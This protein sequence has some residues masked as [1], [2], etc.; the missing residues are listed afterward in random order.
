MYSFLTGP[1][2]WITFLIFIFGT[3]IRLT[4]LAGL[5]K[6]RDSVFY[7]HVDMKWGLKSIF[8][9]LIPWGSVSMRAQPMFTLMF[10]LFHI[11]L[12]LIPLFLSGHNILWDES[13]GISLPSIPDNLA[14]ILTIIFLVAGI[15]LLLRRLIRP[16]V[17][18][19]TS[20][21]DY[22]LLI[23]TILPFLTGFLHIRISDPM[24]Q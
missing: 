15:F 19:L 14:D 9:W 17:R 16:E 13:F 7:N 21:K 18:I 22:V 10:F 2:L 24:K 4:Y 20:V 12:L 8:Y 23:L 6:S 3:I 5:S 1:M 11:P